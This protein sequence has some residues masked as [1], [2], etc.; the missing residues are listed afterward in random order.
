MALRQRLVEERRGRFAERDVLAVAREA[1]DFQPRP[2]RAAEA[3]ALAYRVPVGEVASGESLVDD[4]DAGRAFTILRVEVAPAQDGDVQG[5]EVVQGDRAGEGDVVGHVLAAAARA[6]AAA[7]AVGRVLPRDHHA[8]LPARAAERRRAHQRRRLHAR[9]RRHTLQRTP[10][11]LLPLRLRVAQQVDVERH[12]QHVLRVEA[13]VNA[14]RPLEAA[15]EQARADE[16][17]QRQRDLR[18]DQ[19]VAQGEAPRAPP[20]SA[21][22][23]RR[24][25]FERGDEVGV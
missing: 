14:L 25:V 10:V 16:Q 18:D 8:A 4:D 1:D 13:G 23:E 6:L 17:H 3:D 7:G 19:K 5:L 12:R 22:R 20:A 21:G 11:E 15:Q 24:L 9:Q 2:L